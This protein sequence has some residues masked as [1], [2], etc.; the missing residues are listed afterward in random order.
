[1]ALLDRLQTLQ[2]S[3]RFKV[4]ATAVVALLWIVGFAW[5]WVAANRPD[6]VVAAAKNDVLQVGSAGSF[7]RWVD[8]GPI[9]LVKTGVETATR[10]MRTGEGAALIALGSG[11]FAGVAILVV[12]LGLGLSFLALMVV[13]WG[14]AWPLAAWEPTHSF[15]QVLLGVVPLTLLFLMLMEA[16]KIA[17][18][19]PSPAL[20]I[21]R[22]VLSE[23]VR[24]KVSLVFIVMIILFLAMVPGLLNEN[25][26]LRYRVQ[27]W[28]QYGT[29][30][31]YFMLTLLSLFLSAGTVAFE[32]RDK[33][34]WQT[35]TKPVSHA[36]YLAG[37]WLGVM[38]LNAVLLTITAS[39]VFMFTEYLHHQ[40][41]QGELAYMIR[42]DGKNA[43]PYGPDV[44]AA[45]P[46]RIELLKK[47]KTGV[48]EA[49]LEAIARRQLSQEF[50]S[51]DRRLLELQVLTA[52]VPVFAQAPAVTEDELA[53]L[54][55]QRVKDALSRDPTLTDT[56]K[57]RDSERRRL[58]IEY[59]EQARSVAPGMYREFEFKGL[60]P[61]KER[62]DKGELQ[63]RFKVNAGANDPSSIYRLTFVING[64]A[65]ELS[66]TLK[67]VQSLSIEPEVIGDDGTIRLE[68][69]SS[70]DNPRTM[71]FP[72]DGL[73]ILY[74]VGS[75]ESNFVRIMSV[76]L[77]KLG[78]IAAVAAAA[79]TFLSFPVACLVALSVLFAAE[80]AMFLQDSLDAYYSS[81][82]KTEINY[83]NAVIRA[84]GWP[85]AL[86]FGT[87]AQLEPTDSL[88]EGRLLSWGTLVQAIFIVGS[89]TV[90]TLF[91]GWA[92]FRRRELATY[93]GS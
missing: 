42:A 45:L 77:V 6:A 61:A 47:A 29:G 59:S 87:Y 35:M 26:P 39:G 83:F 1:M 25:Q 62:R 69:H 57:L 38:G 28:M 8:S 60:L 58:L 78:F 37:K 16:L 65:R 67:T 68:V 4:A 3:K 21:A 41:A 20:A 88:V 86:A 76:L 89:W 18:S 90:G 12:W 40:R 17:F 15:G 22:N 24:M 34:I 13:G 49:S 43:M 55:E 66:T 91:L 70:P 23:A 44:T 31:S 5:M 92:V 53:P 93:S 71:T 81:S 74:S 54:I 30:L 14:I 52:R 51:D 2:R 7:A 10:S 85:I 64:Q 72:P 50:M 56:Q 32:Q 33:I 19:G 82:E 79:A 63:L 9:A 11:L 84:I 75:Y 27:Q 48:S 80:S 73:Q 36:G 46:A